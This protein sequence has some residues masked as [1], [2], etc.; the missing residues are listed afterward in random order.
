VI[1]KEYWKL[2]FSELEETGME[3]VYTVS[4]RESDRRA[5]DPHGA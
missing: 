4:R 3:P 1:R 2:W 5:M